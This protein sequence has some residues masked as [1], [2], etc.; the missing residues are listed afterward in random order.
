MENIQDI[1][2]ERIESFN[3]GTHLESFEKE[4]KE[5][6][7]KWNE[8]VEF[9]RIR[10]NKDRKKDNLPAMTFIGVRQKLIALKEIDDLRWFY[11]ECSKYAGTKSKEGDNNTFSK[12]F[13][14]ALKTVKII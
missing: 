11:R 1:L 9:F 7:K 5:Y 4:G 14:G 8:A 13:F 3:K 12:A 10:V 6:N 2:K